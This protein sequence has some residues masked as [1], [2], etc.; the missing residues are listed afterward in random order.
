MRIVTACFVLTKID[1]PLY[2]EFQH[3]AQISA[4]I[5]NHVVE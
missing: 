2:L 1:G 4:Y 5:T 3:N